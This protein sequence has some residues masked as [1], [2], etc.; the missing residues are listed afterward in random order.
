MLTELRI[1]NK[2]EYLVTAKRAM[3]NEQKIQFEVIINSARTNERRLC[4]LDRTGRPKYRMYIL[5]GLT[6]LT[7]QRKSSFEFRVR[8]FYCSRSALT[9]CA[10]LWL[11]R[12]NANDET[13]TIS[14]Q[15]WYT[16]FL[17]SAS[18]AHGRNYELCVSFGYC[19]HSTIVPIFWFT[20]WIRIGWASFWFNSHRFQSSIERDW[21]FGW[22]VGALLLGAC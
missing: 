15:L 2:W 8:L 1:N 13:R 9:L 10:A 19:A 7:R 5:D 20:V 6:S 12:S 21:H 4:C 3:A 17:R 16:L 22:V 18:R 14:H 11:P